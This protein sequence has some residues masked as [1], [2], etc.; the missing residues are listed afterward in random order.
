MGSTMGYNPKASVKNFTHVKE[1]LPELDALSLINLVVCAIIFILGVLGNGL[2]F[3]LFG[4]KFTKLKSFEIFIINL[5]VADFINAVIFPTKNILELTHLNFQQIGLNGCK[6]ISFTS[7]TSM[8]VTALTL[9]TVSIDRFIAIKWPL[10]KRPYQGT[11]FVVIACT[12]LTATLMGSVYLIEGNVCLLSP[13]KNKTFEC[14]SCIKGSERVVFV[15]TVFAVQTGFP[16]I[17]MVVLYTLIVIELNSNCKKRA[18]D[19]GKHNL[20]IHLAQNR[21]ANKMVVLVVAVFSICFLPFNLFYVFNLF[22][23]QPIKNTKKIFNILSLFQMS[24]S[25]ANPIIYSRLHNSFKDSI[26]KTVY[27]YCLSRPK[28]R[29]YQE[30][31]KFSII[32]N[33]SIHYKKRSNSAASNGSIKTRLSSI[34]TS[35]YEGDNERKLSEF[36]EY[37]FHDDS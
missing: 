5:A 20:K 11:V 34:T 17:V 36:T 4:L 23:K 29:S 27:L 18:F 24:N 19:E 31:T 8:T 35:H 33:T 2:V 32:K 12:W 1:N 13:N 6:I 26:K 9:L 16:I 37:A 28:K 10:H 22:I 3:Y 25:I 15:L 14:C 21:K 7:T 30:N